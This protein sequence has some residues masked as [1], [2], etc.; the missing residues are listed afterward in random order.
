M[1]RRAFS[2]NV[3][4]LAGAAALS[5]VVP[6][7]ALALGGEPV[8]GRD[9]TKLTRPLAMANTGKIEVVEFFWYA[10]P[11][12]FAFEPIVEPWI[13]RLPAHVHFRR[14][15]VGF[16]ALKQVHQQIFYTW[17]ALGLV[18]QMHLKTFTRFHVQH[19]AINREDDMLG[20]A[21]ENGLD[22]NKVRQ[23]WNSFSVQT[24]LRQ[25]NQLTEEY[26]ITQMP[27]MG[28]QGR[29]TA[30]ALPSAG[31]ASVLAT[32]DYLVNRIR[33]GG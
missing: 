14:V 24:K 4:R 5:G 8:E 12:C 7:R 10:C 15:P 26:D 20:F 18:E 33:Q 6:G 9:Y 13:A 21:Q 19:K 23:A 28:I 25:A 16:D 1:D 27:E 30:I 17:E 29:F 2:R 31:P 3:A 32:T 11:H 22:V